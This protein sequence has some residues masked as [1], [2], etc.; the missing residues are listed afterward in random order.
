MAVEVGEGGSVGAGAGVVVA[1]STVGA[2][3]LVAVGEEIVGAADP[4][5][6]VGDGWEAACALSL[7]PPQAASPSAKTPKK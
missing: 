1:R 2:G 5:V 6:T 3:T 7:P 4:T